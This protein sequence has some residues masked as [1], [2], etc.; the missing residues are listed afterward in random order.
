MSHGRIADQGT[1]N[2]LLQRKGAYYNLTEAQRIAKEQESTIQDE[3]PILPET[4]YDLRRSVF[5]ENR[6]VSEE[7]EVKAEDPDD[8]QVDRTQSDRI[9]TSTAPAEEGQEDVA[10]NYTLF[11]LIRFVGGLNKIE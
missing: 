5:K 4:E 8:P 10:D 2:D 9:A 3:D 7:K 1:H 11:S 6:Y